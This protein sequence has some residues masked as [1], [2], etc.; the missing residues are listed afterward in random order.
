MIKR[1][2]HHFHITEKELATTAKLRTK[3]QKDI[4]FNG[5]DTSL[6]RIIN[7][8]GFKWRKTVDNRM[9]LLESAIIFVS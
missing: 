3:L 7:E 5:S 8:L 6:R 4:N 2:I 1:Y 9:V